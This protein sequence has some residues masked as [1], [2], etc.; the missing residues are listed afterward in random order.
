MQV[1]RSELLRDERCSQK[2]FYIHA[3]IFMVLQALK[4]EEA[5]LDEDRLSS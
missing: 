5:C 1:V 4:Q 3:V 2:T